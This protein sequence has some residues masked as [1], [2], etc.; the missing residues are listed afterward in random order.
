MGPPIEESGRWWP[1]G[2]LDDI[3]VVTLSG[4]MLSQF[5]LNRKN[6]EKKVR[7]DPAKCHIKSFVKWRA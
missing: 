3:G 1:K 2:R 7:S 4:S 6:A 5:S